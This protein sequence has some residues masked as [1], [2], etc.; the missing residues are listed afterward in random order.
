MKISKYKYAI[1][2]IHSAKTLSLSDKWNI[3]IA[4]YPNGHPESIHLEQ[5][6]DYLHK[7]VGIYFKLQ[8]IK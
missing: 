1:D 5:D 2:L 4:G 6:I 7:K 8:R 3:A